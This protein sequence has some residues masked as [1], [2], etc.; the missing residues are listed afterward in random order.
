[1]DSPHKDLHYSTMKTIPTYALYGETDSHH[2]WLHWETI[3][4]RSR[5]H[6]YRI[7]P[8]RHEEFFQFLALT[9]GRAEVLLDGTRFDLLPQMLVAVPA[10]TVHGYAFSPDVEGVVVTLMERDILGI[11]LDIPAAQVVPATAALT[12]ALAGLIAE[13]DDPGAAHDFAMRAHLTLLLVTLGRAQ[14]HKGPQDETA[15][16][17]RHHAQAFRQ[18]VDRQFR[19]TRRIRDY[20]NAIGIST[21]HLNRVCRQMLA[22]SPLEVIEKRIAL[23]ARRQ[24]LFSSFSIKQIG[25]ELGYDDPAYFTRFLTRVLGVAPGAFRRDGRMRSS[26]APFSSR[27]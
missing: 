15:D 27:A 21:T 7:A 23:E 17:T 4:S 5:L 18:L 9:S 25:A 13:A 2:D 3:Q 22:A 12:S 1:M 16:R 10:L 8:H 20:A 19:Q 6:D 26:A 14:H 24:L 11:G